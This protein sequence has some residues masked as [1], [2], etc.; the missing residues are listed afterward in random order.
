MPKSNVNYS[1]SRGLQEFN[2]ITINLIYD[3]FWPITHKVSS[4]AKFRD[5]STFANTMTILTTY[6]LEQ[7]R[8]YS[9]ILEISVRTFSHP[10]PINRR[11]R[12]IFG[13]VLITSIH[14]SVYNIQQTPSNLTL[15]LE[16]PVSNPN[17]SIAN[18]Y[19]PQ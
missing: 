11:T 18:F 6:S 16:L 12:T 19:H 9:L 5:I 1:Q 7:S 13:L 3:S 2:Y 14:Q 10:K 8:Y 17:Y 15:G 4:M